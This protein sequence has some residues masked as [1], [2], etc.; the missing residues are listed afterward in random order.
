MITF[1]TINCNGDTIERTF[2]SIA[3]I[4]KDYWDE[5]GTTLP[6]SDD[7]VLNYSL[8]GPSITPTNLSFGTFIQSLECQYWHDL[9]LD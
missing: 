1:T 8:N 3:A 7:P 9:V 6:S 2:N 4:L 5:E